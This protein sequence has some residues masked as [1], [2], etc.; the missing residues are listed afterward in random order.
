MS[1]GKGYLLP[2]N[3]DVYELTCYRV[4]VPNKLEYIRAFFGSLDFLATWIAWERTGD[5]RG[6]LAAAAWKDAN[7]A[8]Y[9]NLSLGCDMCCDELNNINTTLGDMNSTLQNY[10]QLMLTQFSMIRQSLIDENGVTV[11]NHLESL[12]DAVGDIG[13][14]PLLV[15]IPSLPDVSIVN[16]IPITIEP[17]IES[18]A[19][20]CLPCDELPTPDTPNI[21]DDIDVENP[22]TGVN[23]EG[24]R[25]YLC[26]ALNYVYDNN[27]TATLNNADGLLGA[28]GVAVSLVQFT[29]AISGH[30]YVAWPMAVVIATWT[31]VKDW[32]NAGTSVTGILSELDTVRVGLINILVCENK[33]TAAAAGN[34]YL[35]AIGA[36]QDAIDWLNQT[37]L[38]PY[39]INAIF[40]ASGTIP[41]NYTHPPCADCNTTYPNAPA[42]WY[43][44]PVELTT[45]DSETGRVPGDSITYAGNEIEYTGQS[46]TGT[47]QSG[48]GF[49]YNCAAATGEVGGLWFESYTTSDAARTGAWFRINLWD[50]LHNQN[51]REL[52]IESDYLQTGFIYL[53]R[54]F[55]AAETTQLSNVALTADVSYIDSDVTTPPFAKIGMQLTHWRDWPLVNYS[56]KVRLWYLVKA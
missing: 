9:E 16:S 38:S 37:L 43:W 8:T 48:A 49:V 18:R 45:L 13:I 30:W 24:Y 29:Y 23:E 17:T 6:S 14:N 47:N 46:G 28:L 32:F 12:A 56:Q 40:D 7:E 21:G 42:G 10:L 33:S 31:M 41:E 52:A 5:N 39:A 36:S 55:T 11:A 2:D 35:T 25:D 34:S 3:P 20:E 26:K 1:E 27:V 4:F 50:G 51:Y 44:E 19:L 22:P 54:L 53:D 15:D